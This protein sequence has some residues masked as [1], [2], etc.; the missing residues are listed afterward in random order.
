MCQWISGLCVERVSQLVAKLV[1][2]SGGVSG[3]CGHVVECGHT[4]GWLG[5]RK[6][7]RKQESVGRREREREKERGTF[8]TT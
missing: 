4:A 1:R 3:S 5:M 2:V 8:S 7:M 6:R